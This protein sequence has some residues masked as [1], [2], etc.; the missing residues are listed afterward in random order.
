LA[1]KKKDLYEDD[2]GH[3]SFKDSWLQNTVQLAALGGIVAGA[4]SLAIHGDLG[5]AFRNG[6]S[7]FQPVGKAVDK[8]IKNRAGMPLKFGYQV[9][10]K[11]VGNMHRLSPEERDAAT[12]N[13]RS[14]VESAVDR[15]DTDPEIQN[16]IWAEVERRLPNESVRQKVRDVRNG[17][18]N[19][20]DTSDE[21]RI[22]TLYEQVRGEERDNLINPSLRQQNQRNN[23]NNNFNRNNNNNNNERLFNRRDLAQK[24]VAS[25]VIGLGT[26]AGLTAFHYIDRMSK[27]P[28]AQQRLEDAYHHAGS[29]MNPKRK[30]DKKMN[31]QAGALE[32]YNAL[33]ESRKKLPEALFAGAGYTGITLGTAKLL[34]SKDPRKN[35]TMPGQDSQEDQNTNGPRVIIE[36]GNQPTSENDHHNMGLPLGLSG[37][38]KVAGLR[39]FWE[40]FKG[41][42]AEI[43]HLRNLHHP[44]LAAE[45]LKN[46]NVEDL[47]KNQ[48]GDL[49]NDKTQANFTNRLFESRTEQSRREAEERIREL[50]TRT[51]KAHLTTGGVAVSGLAGLGYAHHKK[52]Q[53]NV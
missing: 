49:V 8:Y 3:L 34:G 14:M 21:E 11:M 31:K 26:G 6:K 20:V 42:E 2:L 33:K 9:L 40:D 50:E 32:F 22:R 45:A 46:E 37:L 53:N 5:E 44:D 39:N 13:F 30:D 25:G 10:K 36:L 29:F 51:A 12:R 18:S 24:F 19:F 41:H 16:R 27:D 4:G 23:R 15:V 47:L 7:A 38:P 48:Y 28:D 43:E 1:K 17:T 52:E 35:A